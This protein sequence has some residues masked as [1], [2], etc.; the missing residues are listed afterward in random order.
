LKTAVSDGKYSF[1]TQNNGKDTT[2]SPAGMF[3]SY[4]IENNL[5]YVDD[6]IRSYYEF[7]GAKSEEEMIAADEEVKTD[8]APPEEKKKRRGR[9]KKNEEK[10]E[11]EKLDLATEN[12]TITEDTDEEV[13]YMNLPTRK[14]REEQE[15]TEE[16]EEEKTEETP[17]PTRRRRRRA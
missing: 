2:K 5:K 8:V 1:L 16:P 9:P 13:D 11:E 14:K 4:A 10:S 17:A 3:P 12:G 6:K 15:N 7:E